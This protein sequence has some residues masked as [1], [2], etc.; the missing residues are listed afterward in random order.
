MLLCSLEAARH[1]RMEQ[2]GMCKTDVHAN[3]IPR[4]G[5]R[6]ISAV[7]GMPRPISLAAGAINEAFGVFF[8]FAECSIH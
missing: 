1:V 3:L 2:A 5:G 7:L 8:F 4:F 6:G